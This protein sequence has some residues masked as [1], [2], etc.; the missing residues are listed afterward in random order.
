[1]AQGEAN[2]TGPSAAQ[3]L[4]NTNVASANNLAL[5]QAKGEAGGNPAL[6]ATLASN[7][8]AANSMQA[9]QQAAALRAQEQQAGIQQYLQATGQ[10]VTAG[11]RTDED[12][13]AQNNLISKNNSQ[14]FNSAI[15]GAAKVG[16]A[17]AGSGSGGSS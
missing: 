6:A 10:N 15:S 8:S 1:M 13:T 3:A 16:G 7:Q 4:L 5:S 11:Q 14:L 17:F 9:I 12:A 2:G